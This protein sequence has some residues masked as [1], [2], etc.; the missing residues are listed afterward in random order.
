MK[1]L[2]KEDT[3]HMDFRKMPT[4]AYFLDKMEERPNISGGH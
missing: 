3:E 2:D 1:P 4:M